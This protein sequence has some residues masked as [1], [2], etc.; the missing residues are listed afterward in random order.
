MAKCFLIHIRVL[1]RIGSAVGACHQY[2][3]ENR[4]SAR[5]AG[6][7]AEVAVGRSIKSECGWKRVT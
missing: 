3:T 2:E 5:E 6:G 4:I 7:L 1:G